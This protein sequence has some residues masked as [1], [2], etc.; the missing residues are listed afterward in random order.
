MRYRAGT[1]DHLKPDG[2][3]ISLEFAILKSWSHYAEPDT[4]VFLQG[5]PGGSAIRQIPLYA[6]TFEAFRKTRDV[7]LFDQ[8]SAGL[9]GQSVSCFKALAENATSVANKNALPK[10]RLDLLRNA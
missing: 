9:S 8:R 1:E 5:G 6:D 4:V 3:K 10:K 7:L 2:K